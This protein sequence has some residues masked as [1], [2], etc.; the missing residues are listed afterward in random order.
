MTDSEQSPSGAA[1]GSAMVQSSSPARSSARFA[2]ACHVPLGKMSARLAR[3][4]SRRERRHDAHE[5]C[6]SAPSRVRRL[7]PRG[8]CPVDVAALLF[9]KL[10][11]S[12][13]SARKILT[14]VVW[15]TNS[16]WRPCSTTRGRV[17]GNARFSLTCT[18][19]LAPRRRCVLKSVCR[20]SPAASACFSARRWRGRSV[21]FH[22]CFGPDLGH[23]LSCA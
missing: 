3:P 19:K 16:K 6:R 2:V 8:A 18:P 21:K 7:C 17:T 1:K 12:S 20:W 9:R 22:G 14:G 10:P 13:P 11:N 5:T 4:T 15:T 23:Q